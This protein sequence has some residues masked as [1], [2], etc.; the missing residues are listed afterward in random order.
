[1]NSFGTIWSV[2]CEYTLSKLGN[3]ELIY[4]DWFVDLSLVRRRGLVS[5]NLVIP[6]EADPVGGQKVCCTF[7]TGEPRTRARYAY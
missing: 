2:S 5:K 4:C 6:T 7:T 3:G 1:M